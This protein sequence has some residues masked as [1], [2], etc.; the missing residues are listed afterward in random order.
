MTGFR[1]LLIGVPRYDDPALPDLPSVPD[2]LDAL[3]RALLRVG[4]EVVAHDGTRTDRDRVDGAL[5]RFFGSA[6]PGQVLLVVIGGHGAHVGGADHLVPAGAD[7]RSR[8]FA[9]RC[10]PVDVAEHVAGSACGDVLVVLDTCRGT[11]APRTDGVAYLAAVGGDESSHGLLTRALTAAVGEA[12]GLAEVVAAVRGRVGPRVAVSGGEFTVFPR[13]RDTGDP[14]AAAVR[15]HPAWALAPEDAGLRDATAGLVG[16]WTRRTPHGNTPADDRWWDDEAP[17]RAADHLGLLLTRAGAPLTPADAALLAVFPFARQAFLA[18]HLATADPDADRFARGRPRVARRLERASAAGDDRAVAD[19][20]WWLRH[21][22][23]AHRGSRYEAEAV[24]AAL[25]ADVPFP[26]AR[27]GALVRDLRSTRSTDPLARVLTAAHLLALDPADLP[28][29]IAEHLGIADPVDLADLLTTV[30]AASWR[31]RGHVL[32]LHAECAHQAV[33]HALTEHVA[34]V[35]GALGRLDPPAHASADGVRPTLLP[36]GTPSHDGRGFRFRLADDRVQ[37]L[38]MGVQLYGDPGLAVRELHQNALDA[39]RYRRARTEHLRR[40]GADV[41]P[42]EGRIRFEQGVDEHGRPYLD[43]ADNGIGMGHHEL[44]GVFSH[45]GAR[46][47]DLP[48]FVEEEAEWA[49]TG[50]SFH[51]NSRFGIGVLG[52]FM[53]ADEL[54]VT[55][56][57]LGRDGRPG[58]RLRV[59]VPGPGALSRVRDLGP[60]DEA[61]TTVRLYPRE[62]GLSCVDELRKVLL[63]SEFEVEAVDGAR[64]AAWAAG[65]VTSESLTPPRHEAVEVLP[66]GS[67]DVWWCGDLGAVLADGLRAGVATFGVVVNLTGPHAPRLTV[68]RR[69][70]V[71]LD[72]GLV[73][74]LVAG[75]AADFAGRTALHSNRWIG[76]L[77]WQRPA[78]ADELVAR[79]TLAGAAWAAAGTSVDP[80][81]VGCFP[82]DDDFFGDA[83][84]EGYLFERVPDQVLRWRLA[85]WSGAGLVPGLTVADE[86]RPVARPSDARLLREATSTPGRSVGW[87]DPRETV[88]VAHVAHVSARLSRTPAEVA[89]RLT[90]LG[91]AVEGAAALSPADLDLL[92]AGLDGQA[93][94]LEPGAPV[95]LGHALAAAEHLRLAPGEV[96]DRLAAL[97][98]DVTPFDPAVDHAPGDGPL[99]GDPERP[100]DDRWLPADRPVP[101]AHVLRTAERLGRTP[102]DVAARL[103][104]LGYEVRAFDT[105]A[106]PDEHDHTALSAD[107]G[108]PYPALPPDRVVPAA[109]LHVAAWATGRTVE[110]VA[111]RLELFG[112]RVSRTGPADPAV[113]LRALLLDGHGQPLPLDEVVRPG[114]VLAAALR[115]GLAVDEVVERLTELGHAVTPFAHATAT[116]DDL[117]LLS[118]ELDGSPPWLPG[119]TEVPLG[120]VLLAADRLG[121]TASEVA[122]RLARFG[123]RC[124]A[125]PVP[126][127]RDDV[128]LVSEDLDAAAPWLRRGEPVRIGHLL[129]AAQALGKPVREVAERLAELGFRLPDGVRPA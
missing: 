6:A 129:R 101:S 26:P 50:V 77:V 33:S 64:R 74:R 17:L 85:V 113:D 31:S 93:P 44:T 42:W 87:L 105:S 58:R 40:T 52:Y 41:P 18:H 69:R 123:Y 104:A 119:G 124:A 94:W 53:V 11:G 48:E 4:Y 128:R 82:D 122:A 7:T 97:G 88:P 71:D 13:P 36:D 117:V 114:H 2:D 110:H 62:P 84:F 80:A 81:S 20:R 126:T 45:A 102:A 111:G 22:A 95:P 107:A 66:S 65:V 90:A 12:T 99:L 5:E 108:N 75:Q 46:F 32:A 30:R 9:D 83:E 54:T 98:H 27:L 47:P 72:E 125:P 61:G 49:R 14:W 92:S 19:L 24:T 38:L 120:H 23:L 29:A 106:V 67:P 109:H 8:R 57:R 59:E 112:Y 16:R 79:A 118:A 73:D 28:S 70:I 68:D 55:T 96:R 34:R 21:R 127:G 3:R 60:G 100:A 103:R 63:L 1:A 10:L 15:A 51:P 39:C 86:P 91:F 116:A 35:S 115:T 76:G 56:C 121:A 43:C 37:E 25:G 78:V 89:D